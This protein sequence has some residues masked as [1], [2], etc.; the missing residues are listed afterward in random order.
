MRRISLAFIVTILGATA[1]LAQTETQRQ[2]WVGYDFMLGQWKGEGTGSPGE[3]VGGF[4]FA[5]DLQGEILVRKNYAVYPATSSRPGFRHDDLMIVYHDP[6]GESRAMY[7]DNEGHAIAY[8]AGLK[9]G[10]TAV[11]VS[12][13]GAT[14]PRFRLTYTKI[15]PDSLGILFEIAPPPNPEK[16]SPYINARA[17]RVH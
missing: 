1:C 6:S 17:Y 2:G 11:F 8:H 4:T 13:S 15:G 14:G 12:D 9:P 7:F 3:G 5:P 10:G 16:F